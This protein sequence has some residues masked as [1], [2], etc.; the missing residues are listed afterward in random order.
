VLNA[1]VH[2]AVRKAMFAQVLWAYL[3]R[4]RAVVLDVPLLFE[5]ALDVFCGT[6]LVV[7]VRDPEVQLQRLLARDRAQGGTLT[8]LE[9]RERLASQGDVRGKVARVGV[10]GRGWGETVWND[11]GR[12]DL[13]RE[14]HRVM[15]QVEAASPRWWSLL[16]WACPPLALVMALRAWMWGREARRRFEEME[17]REKAK[18]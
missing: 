14:V 1:V 7:G 10:R 16:C 13:R 6:V 5:S 18:L 17:R 3:R 15:G 2:P 4:D 9:A 11:G 8:E 12:E